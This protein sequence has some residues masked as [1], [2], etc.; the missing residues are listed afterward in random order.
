M[1]VYL[2]AGTIRMNAQ[3]FILTDLRGAAVSVP[4]VTLLGYFLSEKLDNLRRT[5][6]GARIITT[7]VLMLAVL[8]FL[9]YRRLARDYPRGWSEGIDKPRLAED[10]SADQRL[11]A[12]KGGALEDS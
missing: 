11:P 3:K 2:V 8:G 1:A 6:Q 10:P 4:L 12:A 5:I 9:L 7:V